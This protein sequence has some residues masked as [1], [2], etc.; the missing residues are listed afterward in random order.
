MTVISFIIYVSYLLIV[1]QCKCIKTKTK[2][3]KQNTA[4]NS[5]IQ[6]S[7]EWHVLDSQSSLG[8]SLCESSARSDIYFFIGNISK[9]YCISFQ[10]IIQ[11]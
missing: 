9:K 10:G 6:F 4:V 11:R 3:H 1:K 2:C 8:S 7:E 5:L